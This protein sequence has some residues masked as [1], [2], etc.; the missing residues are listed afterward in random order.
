L[1]A[2]STRR[3]ACHPFLL[4]LKL[5]G[6]SVRAQVFIFPLLKQKQQTR[7]RLGMLQRVPGADAV[8]HSKSSLQG[9]V[10]VR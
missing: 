4:G 1:T 7:A 6:A 2:N 5:D 3:R 9:A 10:L 8:F